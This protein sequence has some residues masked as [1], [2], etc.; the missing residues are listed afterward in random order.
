MF[1]IITK[2]G[3]HEKNRIVIILMMSIFVF[4]PKK[5]FASLIYN[6]IHIDYRFFVDED[7]SNEGNLYFKLY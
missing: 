3:Y 6:N 2:E 7:S 4:A 1:F 5:V